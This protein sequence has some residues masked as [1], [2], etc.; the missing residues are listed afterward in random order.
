MAKKAKLL[1]GVRLAF[2]A[3]TVVVSTSAMAD[4]ASGDTPEQRVERLI[5]AIDQ[6]AVVAATPGPQCQDGGFEKAGFEK[7]FDKDVPV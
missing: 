6:A 3:A 7:D 5:A 2:G 4:I 1:A